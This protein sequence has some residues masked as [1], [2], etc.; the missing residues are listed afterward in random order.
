MPD[1]PHLKNGMYAIL[2]R[3]PDGHFGNTTDGNGSENS[4]SKMIR[5][6]CS[7]QRRGGVC[8]IPPHPGAGGGMCRFFPEWVGGIP[9][10]PHL[11]PDKISSHQG[12]FWGNHH[13]VCKGRPWKNHHV[14]RSGSRHRKFS[15]GDEGMLSL[16]VLSPAHLIDPPSSLLPNPLHCDKLL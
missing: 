6:V 4:Y 11:F 9:D 7:G 13:C 14:L 5:G 15:E 10:T 12:C 8:W 3:Y 16:P 1:T 2:H